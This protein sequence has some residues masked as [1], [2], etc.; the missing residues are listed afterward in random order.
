VRLKR[1]IKEG[2][3][4]TS[5]EEG[6]TGR[7][8]PMS[9]LEAKDFIHKHC[10]KSLF[11]TPIWRGTGAPVE[12]G[13]DAFFIQPSKFTRASRNASNHYTLLIDNSSK[14]SNYPQR[15]KSVICTTNKSSAGF[16]GKTYRIFPV[17]GSD[18]GICPSSDFWS[19]FDDYK[20]LDV[21][22]VMLVR[23]V[24]DVSQTMAW[25]KDKKPELKEAVA[26][27]QSDLTAF[28]NASSYSSILNGFDYVDDKKHLVKDIALN[29][30]E[31]NLWRTTNYLKLHDYWKQSHTKLIDHFNFILSPENNAFD[32]AKAGDDLAASDREVWTDGNCV[33]IRADALK[34]END[35]FKK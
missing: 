22:N 27:P 35:W 29:Q 31:T 28:I 33:M 1:Y 15:S 30:G 10:K 17:D 7:K 26:L 9:N 25:M 23:L 32:L 19:A 34:I 4:G 6:Y 2:E 11:S 3:Y 5:S 16:Y 13:S 21:F 8:V 14:W 18:I 20:P 24:R 12:G